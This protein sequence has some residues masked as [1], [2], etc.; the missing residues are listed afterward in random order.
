MTTRTINGRYIL[1][2]LLGEGGMGSV[3]T[4]TDRLN[5]QI[6]AL[7]RVRLPDYHDSRIDSQP[8]DLAFRRALT[9]EFQVLASLRHPHIIRVLDYGVDGDGVPFFTMDHLNQAQTI[10]EAGHSQP[11]DRQINLLAQALR[12]L[13]YLH[14]RAVLHRDLKPGNI[15]V[16]EGTLKVVDFGVA[17]AVTATNPNTRVGTLHYMAPEVVKDGSTTELSD[18]YSLG[19]IAYE[20]LANQLPFEMSSAAH[21]LTAILSHEPDLDALDVSPALRAVIGRLLLKNPTDR[22]PNAEAVL[23]ALQEASDLPLQGEDPA[24]RESFLQAAS[25][26]GRDQEFNLLRSQLNRAMSGQGNTWLIGGES[27]V[28]KSR[29]VDELRV[30][31]LVK[32]FLVL[33]GQG[34]AEGGVLFQFW[35]DVARSL[36]LHV[37]VEQQHVEALAMIVP[38]IADILGRPLGDLSRISGQGWRERIVQTIVDL[39]ERYEHPLLIILEDLQWAGESLDPL[40]RLSE[41]D[42]DRKLMIL[43]TF[44][45]DEMPDLPKRVPQAEL[46][47]L[48]R[49]SEDGIA[50]LSASMLGERGRQ[51]EIVALLQRE[52]EGNAYFLVEV[53]RALAESAGS[54]DRIIEADLPEA[55][56]AEGVRSVLRSRIRRV[57]DWGME[58]LKLAAVAGRQ[59][60]LSLL[61]AALPDSLPKEFSIDD[62]LNLCSNVAVLEVQEESWRFAHDKLREALVADLDEGERQRLN[63]LVAETLEVL[64]PDDRSQY[65]TLHSHWAAAGDL[66]KEREY[67]MQAAENLEYI[68]VLTE[69]QALAERALEITPASM[70]AQRAMALYTLSNLLELRNQ[71]ERGREAS[72]EGLKLARDSGDIP[73][74]IKCLGMHSRMTYLF[75]EYDRAEALA[76]EGLTLIET[77]PDANVE[78]SLWGALGAIYAGR[79]DYDKAI[80]YDSKALE[81]VKDTAD[82]YRMTVMHLNIGYDHSEA[83]NIGEGIK[84]FERAHKMANEHHLLNLQV[85]MLYNLGSNYREVERYDEAHSYMLQAIRLAKQID[86]DNLYYTAMVVVSGWL[87]LSGMAQ[88]SAQILGFA[89]DQL[90]VNVESQ[91]AFTE[92]LSWL[93]GKLPAE[94]LTQQMEEGSKLSE[95]QAF[96]L[97]TQALMVDLPEAAKKKAQNDE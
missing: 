22:Y 62:W 85:F 68:G 20:M 75:G 2:D 34:V 8:A 31:A 17:A 44:R 12:A 65:V 81:L 19:V 57:P 94:E 13:A 10:I 18:L 4:A 49:L 87:A 35:V 89:R 26:V 14:R 52:T 96:I 30:E 67:A 39:V 77:H 27:G 45:D 66:D 42:D 6:V 47:S 53:V 48:G 24:I 61:E 86:M 70:P 78:A 46:M 80:E 3:Y 1:H 40:I 51:P 33:G 88:K 50:E 56:F 76:R 84:W 37:P 29:L 92:S 11:P 21:L 64:H 95:E 55:V 54:L 7:K 72:A 71:S 59:L 91:D 82:A 43:G 25:F 5:G 74:L 90:D 58:V 41:R 38:N 93:Q 9:R 63:R 79:R 60:N 23:Q 73:I 83:G 32:N 97:A 16:T 28:G 15:L 36:L 69:A